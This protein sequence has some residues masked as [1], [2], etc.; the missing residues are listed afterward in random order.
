MPVTAS[1][2]S[3][4]IVNT[5]LALHA[6]KAASIA[7]FL[8]R[9]FGEGR[10]LTPAQARR[11]IESEDLAWTA[12]GAEKARRRMMRAASDAGYALDVEGEDGGDYVLAD[13]VA[14]IEV[15]GSL[16]KRPM[17]DLPTSMQP[18]STVRLQERWHRALNDDR[19]HAILGCMDSPGG[20]ID[21]AFE[22]QEWLLEQRGVKPTGWFIDGMGASAGYGI[23]C[24]ADPGNLW[25]HKSAQVGSVGILCIRPDYSEHARKEG[26]RYNVF[27]SDELK[28]ESL[29]IVPVSDAAAAHIMS[30]VAV[31]TGIFYDHVATARGVTVEDVAALRSGCYIASDERASILTDRLGRFEHALAAMMNHE[32]AMTMPPALQPAAKPATTTASAK[33]AAKG[34]GVAASRVRTATGGLRHTAEDAPAADAPSTEAPA[35]EA[36]IPDKVSDE[37]VAALESRYPNLCGEIRRRAAEDA[38]DGDGAGGDGGSAPAGGGGESGGTGAHA[39]LGEL[40]ADFPGDANAPFVLRMAN[41][42]VTLL[43]AHREHAKVRRD[44]A[45]RTVAGV[46]AGQ[47]TEPVGSSRSGSAATASAAANQTPQQIWDTNVDVRQHRAFQGNVKL[48]EAYHKSQARANKSWEEC[49]HDDQR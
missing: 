16:T 1:E 30:Q 31:L 11:A 33:G 41:K 32:G 38:T 44:G 9:R 13:G 23:A 37:N 19:V 48:F 26:I 25:A 39:T 5:P 6:G 22:F 18:V 7:E 29:G 4:L 45:V 27:T 8:T 14:V 15:Y 12:E 35:M 20:D 17:D 34:G 47:S 46:V 10:R 42:G 3:G 21:G 36:P 28:T 43:T 40:T 24:T 2:L 49:L